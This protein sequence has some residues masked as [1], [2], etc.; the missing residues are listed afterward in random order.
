VDPNNMDARTGCASE[1]VRTFAE[2]LMAAEVDVLRNA[3]YGEVTLE[4]TNSRNAY[5]GRRLDTRM[6]T[7]DV[8]R[9]SP[10]RSSRAAQTPKTSETG[11]TS[12][13]QLLTSRS[14]CA[15]DVP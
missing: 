14:P 10:S 7:V 11:T 12:N 15:T 5:R 2:R 9:G 6:G 3:G 4:H 13:T 8:S 1:M